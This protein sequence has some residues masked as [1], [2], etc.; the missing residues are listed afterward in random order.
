MHFA[1]LPKHHA[2]LIT[3]TNRSVV[4]ASLFDELCTTSLAHKLFDQTVLDIDTSREIIS[5]SKIPY[6]EE[7]VG[8]ISFHTAGIPA[9]NAMLKILEEPPYRTRFILITNNKSNLID[10]VLSRLQYHGIENYNQ[11]VE[12][13]VTKEAGLFLRTTPNERMRLNFVITLLNKTDEEDRKDR[14]S[15]RSFILSLVEELPPDQETSS[16]YITEIL[17]TASY[18]GDPSSSGKA[19]L[20]YLSLLLPQTKD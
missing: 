10:T 14:E 5:W 3:S 11:E 13:R 9:Q 8:I 6:H 20:E 7:R 17:Q 12:Q 2:I 1:S 18:A 4:A 16:R 19:L 15:V